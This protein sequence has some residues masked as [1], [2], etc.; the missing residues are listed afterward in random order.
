MSFRGRGSFLFIL[1]DLVTLLGCTKCE[2]MI[3]PFY[4][5]HMHILILDAK[6]AIG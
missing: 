4:A 3:K 5:S 2:Y 6:D 1:T